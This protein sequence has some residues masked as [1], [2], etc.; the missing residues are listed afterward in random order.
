[1]K[2]IDPATFPDK[3]RKHRTSPTRHAYVL[4]PDASRDRPYCLACALGIEAIDAVGLERAELAGRFHRR[5]RRSE[6]ML[7]AGFSEM[8]GRGLEDAWQGHCQRFP[9]DSD[10]FQGWSDGDAAWQACADANLI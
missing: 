9:Y 10:Y 8:Y 6:L 3:F 1:M 7:L 2:R 5:H 4:P